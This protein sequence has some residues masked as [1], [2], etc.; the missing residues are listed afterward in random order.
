[1]SA[2]CLI[3]VCTQSIADGVVSAA[4]ILEKVATHS[5]RRALCCKCQTHL[6]ADWLLSC[7]SDGRQ[8]TLLT[9]AGLN[10]ATLAAQAHATHTGG[11]TLSVACSRPGQISRD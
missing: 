2:D 11:D 1:M 3:G 8:S 7:A 9:R 6:V 10:A 4:A 5:P